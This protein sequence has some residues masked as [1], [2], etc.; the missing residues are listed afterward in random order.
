[1]R[2]RR[3]ALALL[4]PLLVAGGCGGDDGSSGDN[5]ANGVES[6]PPEQVLA[7]AA[8]ALREVK[9]FHAVAKEGKGGKGRR[10]QAD[11]AVPGKLRVEFEQAGASA[12]MIVIDDSNY[13]NANAAFWKQQAD[14]GD[15]AAQL[16]G[17]W[18][19][20]PSSVGSDLTK[21]FDPARLSRCLVK[22]HGTLSRGGTATVGGRPA[23]VIVD[24]GDRP[25]T[26]PGRLY[27]AATGDP[28][29]LRMIATGRERPGGSKDPECD[30]DD[31]PAT[32]GD[33]V[34]LSGYDEPVDIEEPAAAVDL[35]GGGTAS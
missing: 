19:K 35:S 2:G 9:S 11:V 18:F 27:V 28:L 14:A 20:A 32:P 13:V 21:E 8:A 16:A 31:S 24:R 12:S 29:P 10:L 5:G 30:A 3:T 22:G 4:L 26:N 23:V 25:G 17:R 33:E 15:Q 6:K 7:D 34:V 1:M